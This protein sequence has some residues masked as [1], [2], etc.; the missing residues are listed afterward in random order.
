MGSIIYTL[1]T[2]YLSCYY[3]LYSTCIHFI[4]SEVTKGL[5]KTI[6]HMKFDITINYYHHVTLSNTHHPPHMLSHASL[7][8]ASSKERGNNMHISIYQE[9]NKDSDL[10]NH[11]LKLKIH[12][13]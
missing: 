3:K 8:I 4:P 10:I 9:H 6:V 13:T 5:V 2:R 11:P 7:I 12:H 1:V